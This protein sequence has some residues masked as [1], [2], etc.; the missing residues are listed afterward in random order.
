MGLKIY[1]IPPFYGHPPYQAT[2]YTH[3]LN[4]FGNLIPLPTASPLKRGTIATD[5]NL[6]PLIKGGRGDQ[7]LKI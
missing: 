7:N 3:L 1:K 5:R 2:V 4:I 6:A